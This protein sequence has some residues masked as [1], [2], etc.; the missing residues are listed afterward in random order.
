VADARNF[1]PSLPIIAEPH[2]LGV[3]AFIGSVVYDFTGRPANVRVESCYPAQ[4][5]GCIV[6]CWS[7]PFAIIDYYRAVVRQ[8]GWAAAQTFSRLYMI[9]GLY[10]CPCGQPVD[11]DPATIVQLMPQL[12]EWVEHGET[13][14]EKSSKALFP[15]STERPIKTCGPGR[16]SA[17]RRILALPSGVTSGIPPELRMLYD[18]QNEEP[19]AYLS[20]WLRQIPS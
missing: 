17:S 12:V 8:S 10:H 7:P 6:E 1:L 20:Y 19:K 11:G 3:S 18:P 14:P 2:R 16:W 13:R 5:L 4:P 15:S 9:P